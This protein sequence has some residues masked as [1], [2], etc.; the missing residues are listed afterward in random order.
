[1]SQVFHKSKMFQLYQSN[2]VTANL[3]K[4]GGEIAFFQIA[5]VQQNSSS[6]FT[7]SVTENLEKKHAHNRKDLDSQL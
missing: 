1:M 5:I 7:N 6:K 2:K 4:P 3:L